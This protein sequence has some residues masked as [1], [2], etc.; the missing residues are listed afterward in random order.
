PNILPEQADSNPSVPELT[1]NHLAYVIYTSGSIGMPKGVMV[2]HSGLSNYLN[3]AVQAYAPEEGAVV[4]SSLSFDATVTSLWIPLLYGST[5]Q[6]L[7][8][9]NEIEA[10]EAYV[11][12]ARGEGLVKITPVHL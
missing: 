12:Q 9:G 2:V 10:L 5:V 8:A 7:R 1:A 11:R 3:W 6:L 4:S